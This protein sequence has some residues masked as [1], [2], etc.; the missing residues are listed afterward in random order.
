MATKQRAKAEGLRVVTL[1]MEADTDLDIPDGV[2]TLLDAPLDLDEPDESSSGNS[3]RLAQGSFADPN[4]PIIV[5]AVVDGKAIECPI[6]GQ[7]VVYLTKKA[8]DRAQKR[9]K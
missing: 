3:F 9:A 6:A 1:L 8:V 2:E 7:T 4:A 5:K